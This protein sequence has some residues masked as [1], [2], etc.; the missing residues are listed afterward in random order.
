LNSYLMIPDFPHDIKIRLAKLEKNC[1]V[2]T[3][4][5]LCP[6][7]C[8]SLA[9]LRYIPWNLRYVKIWSQVIKNL[10]HFIENK[11]CEYTFVSFSFPQSM[12]LVNCII[13]IQDFLNLKSSDAKRPQKA[14]S[15]IEV[16]QS[17]PCLLLHS[18]SLNG[19]L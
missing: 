5:C 14:T 1:C 18:F 16:F 19:A 13:A 17:L 6:V 15:K 11:D 7:G 2:L 12:V 4:L 10:K 9:K 3:L 8:L